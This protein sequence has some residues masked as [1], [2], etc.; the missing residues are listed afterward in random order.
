MRNNVKLVCKW[1]QLQKK[2]PHDINSKLHFRISNRIGLLCNFFYSNLES[3]IEPLAMCFDTIYNKIS[4]KFIGIPKHCTNCQIV[5]KRN[6]A[7]PAVFNLE[8][9][10]VNK[11]KFFDKLR[12]LGTDIF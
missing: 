10:F 9:L 4:H 5:F 8:G 3:L 11:N 1:K 7:E 6:N 2:L 12:K